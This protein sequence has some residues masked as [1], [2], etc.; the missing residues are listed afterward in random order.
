MVLEQAI[1]ALFVFALSVLLVRYT[2]LQ[3][4]SGTFRTAE[5]EFLAPNCNKFS[6]V[7]DLRLF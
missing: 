7:C 3:Q 2:D 6:A 5:N 1:I 4:M